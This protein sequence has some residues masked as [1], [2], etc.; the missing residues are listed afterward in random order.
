M[1][2]V[3][4]IRLNVE[5]Y[6]RLLQTNLDEQ[7]RRATQAMLAEFERKLVRPELTSRLARPQC[8]SGRGRVTPKTRADAQDTA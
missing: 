6:R 2:E 7:T 4:I 8:P 5:R 3:E 1:E